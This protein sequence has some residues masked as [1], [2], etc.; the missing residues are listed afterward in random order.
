MGIRSFYTEFHSEISTATADALF[1][2]S[3]DIRKL[4]E[5][6][7][8]PHEDVQLGLHV[9]GRDGKGSTVRV[10]VASDRGVDVEHGAHLRQRPAVRP[11]EDGLYD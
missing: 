3:D 4:G 9:G 1:F 2:F 10:G 7:L 11:V 5:S 6:E 8:L